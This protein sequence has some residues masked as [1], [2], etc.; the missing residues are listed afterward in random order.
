MSMYALLLVAF[1]SKDYCFRPHEPPSFVHLSIYL[2][3][4]AT[5][6]QFWNLLV[7]LLSPDMVEFR[8]GE[9]GCCVHQG[10]MVFP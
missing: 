6:A 10:G 3:N 1:C 8:N 7:R 5:Y 2:H 9:A 4:V